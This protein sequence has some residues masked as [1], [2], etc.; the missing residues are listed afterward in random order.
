MILLCV[1]CE[2]LFENAFSIEFGKKLFG[3]ITDETL[4]LVTQFLE[5]ELLLE[6]TQKALVS[7]QVN[8]ITCQFFD[9]H[10]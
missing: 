6:Q 7:F 10:I 9:T 1:H 3:S 5:Q 2:D 8:S 4:L